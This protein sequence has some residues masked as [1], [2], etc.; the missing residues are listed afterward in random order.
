MWTTPGPVMPETVSRPAPARCLRTVAVTDRS[1][2]V[3]WPTVPPGLPRVGGGGCAGKPLDGE[4]RR[5]WSAERPHQH[6]PG[7]RQSQDRQQCSQPRVAAQPPQHRSGQR[8]I[9]PAGE[10]LG[11]RLLAHSSMLP[12]C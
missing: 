1:D 3:A 6:Q 7:S 11:A 10:D 2:G 4:R 8:L 5:P 9:A 12:A